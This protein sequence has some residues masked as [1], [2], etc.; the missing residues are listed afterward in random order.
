MEMTGLYPERDVIIEIATVVTDS[1]LNLLEQG[2][3]FIIHREPEWFEKMDDWNKTHHTKSG[4]WEQVLKST[5]TESY[6]EQQTI[7]FLK[8]HSKPK[9]SP[10][11]GNSV[12]QDRRFLMRYMPKL[13]E[14][15]H[16]RILDVSTIK[17][18]TTHWYPDQEKYSVKKGNHR[19]LDDILES[20]EELR[21]YR[22]KYFK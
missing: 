22:Q 3:H 7:E 17:E 2:P 11:C 19:A 18:V 15:L 13:D 14:F 16:Y 10:L 20:I 6:A 1:E 21:F 12:W 9:S 8:Q 4:L 5:T